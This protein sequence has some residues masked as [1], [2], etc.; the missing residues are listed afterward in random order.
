MSDKKTFYVNLLLTAL[1]LGV[2]AIAFSSGLGLVMASNQP[3]IV[4]AADNLPPI[5]IVLFAPVTETSIDEVVLDRIGPSLL[6]VTDTTGLLDMVASEKPQ[7]IVIDTNALDLVDESWLREQYNQGVILGVL[8]GKQGQLSVKLGLISPAEL[9]SRPPS[10]YFS[11]PYIR[12]AFDYWDPAFR[13][14]MSGRGIIELA[15]A[16][17]FYRKVQGIEEAKIYNIEANNLK[18]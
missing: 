6:L 8:N 4:Q 1:L 5:K 13:L 10:P 2:T 14:G 3:D 15:E 12:Y 7:A 16:G 17:D 9:A 18:K 11:Q